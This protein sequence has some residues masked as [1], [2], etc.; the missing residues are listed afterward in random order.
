MCVHRATGFLCAIK[1]I[2]KSTLREYGMEGQ[3]ASELRI[4]YGLA[5]PNVVQLYA[6]FDDEYHIFLLM[7]YAC[8]GSLME[9]L[10]S[11]EPEAARAVEQVLRAV[12]QLHRRRV[13]HRDIK[14]ENVVVSL[15]VRVRRCRWP[16]CATSAGR[17]SSTTA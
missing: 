14:P 15:G 16:S 1:K 8:D 11:D 12:E 13:V 17:P 2:F 10:R 7:E 4:H 3:L 9:R 6:H 5:H